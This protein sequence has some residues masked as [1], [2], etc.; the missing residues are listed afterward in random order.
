MRLSLLI[1]ETSNKILDLT[2][3]LYLKIVIILKRPVV[4]QWHRMCNCKRDG[5]EFDSH[6]GERVP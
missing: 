5:C 4:A 1:K 2:I 6:S 3:T